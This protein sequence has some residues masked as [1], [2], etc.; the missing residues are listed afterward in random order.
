MEGWRRGSGFEAGLKLDAGDGVVVVVVVVVG[1]VA[2][3]AAASAELAQ[4]EATTCDNLTR[5]LRDS[6]SGDVAVAVTASARLPAIY[7]TQ[8]RFVAARWEGELI[9]SMK[10]ENVHCYPEVD[11]RLNYTDSH[12]RVVVQEW[13]A[14]MSSRTQVERTKALSEHILPSGAPSSTEHL[15]SGPS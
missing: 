6:S 14:V 4:C 11:L 5:R 2:A 10:G 13:E 8:E 12:S 1:D 15:P 3:A 9:A 7:R